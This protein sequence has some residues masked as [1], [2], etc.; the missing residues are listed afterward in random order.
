M[1]VGSGPTGYDQDSAQNGILFAV[2]LRTGPTEA[3]VESAFVTVFATDEKNASLR[4]PSAVDVDLD[5]RVDALYVGAVI[6]P[7]HQ[8]QQPWTGKMYRLGTAHGDPDPTH[9]GFGGTS[10]RMPT[11][12]VSSVGGQ[13]VLNAGDEVD[14]FDPSEFALKAVAPSTTRAT[15]KGAPDPAKI[16]PEMIGPVM[17]A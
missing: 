8:R 17:G 2:D 12:L 10:A 13:G 5:Y 3:N 4:D 11:V 1:V 15:V 16:P 9:W 14:L 6:H 7:W